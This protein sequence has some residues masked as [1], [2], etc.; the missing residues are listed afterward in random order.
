MP[1]LPRCKV[2]TLSD[3]V[4]SEYYLDERLYELRDVGNPHARLG[5]DDVLLGTLAG[6]L[7]VEAVRDEEEEDQNRARK[8]W[9][10]AE[11]VRY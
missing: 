5:F 1:R 10:D 11:P 2:T 4:C 8:E 3:G 7:R 6:V 9:E